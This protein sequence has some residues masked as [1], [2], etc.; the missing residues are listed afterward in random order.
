[1]EF[2]QNAKAWST[3]GRLESLA[4]TFSKA[5]A[6]LCGVSHNFYRLKKRKK[7]EW[8]R[9]KW[10]HASAL[11]FWKH[12]SPADE[13]LQPQSIY[14]SP[15]PCFSERASIP[16]HKGSCLRAVKRRL[17]FFRPRALCPPAKINGSLLKKPPSALCVCRLYVSPR[18]T[19]PS[20]DSPYPM[21]VLSGPQGCGKRELTHRLCQEF[22]QYFAYGSVSDAFFAHTAWIQEVG[23]V[24]VCALMLNKWLN[25]VN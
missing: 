12:R 14:H 17:L 2:A 21:L 8:R 18:S 5:A 4:E 22:S 7:K 19:L 25:W 6:C 15:P 1:M 23:S 20:T 13:T 16:L 24:I 11:S 9:R 10:A 3:G